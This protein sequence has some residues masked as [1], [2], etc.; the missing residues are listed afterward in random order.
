MSGLHRNA[1]LDDG[2]ELLP[3]HS[4]DVLALFQRIRRRYPNL[5]DEMNLLV[6]LICDGELSFA[7]DK[8]LAKYW[9]TPSRARGEEVG[10]G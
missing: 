9:A 4:D 6:D 2:E 7:F 8:A 1:L 5:S 10:N 3:V